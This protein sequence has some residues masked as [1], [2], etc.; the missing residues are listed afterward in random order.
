MISFKGN[1]SG[2]IDQ[3]KKYLIEKYI[4]SL[5]DYRN[6][7]YSVSVFNLTTKEQTID[8]NSHQL[9]RPASVLKIIPCFLS[10]KL[11]ESYYTDFIYKDDTLNV[12]S[13]GDISFLDDSTYPIYPDIHKK[14]LFL[15]NKTK[16]I[17]F[18]VDNNFPKREECNNHFIEEDKG[19]YFGAVPSQYNFRGNR[20]DFHFNIK[21]NKLIFKYVYPNPFMQNVKAIIKYDITY[22]PPGTRDLT[23]IYY[24]NV[25]TD[26]FYILFKGTY[27]LIS[28]E[29]NLDIVIKGCNPINNFQLITNHFFSNTPS[30][31]SPIIV[32]DTSITKLK[33]FYKLNSDSIINSY[34]T[35]YIRVFSN[36][37]NK[38]LNKCLIESNNLIANRLLF[39]FGKASNM[40]HLSCPCDLNV[41]LN[42]LHDTLAQLGLP[43]NEFQLFEGSGLSPENKISTYSLS[44]FLL[45]KQNPYILTRFYDLENGWQ[46]GRSTKN[47]FTK[48]GYME[49]TRSLAGYFVRKDGKMYSFAIIVNDYKGQAGQSKVVVDNILDILSR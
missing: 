12:Y 29:S 34:K 31:N 39:D 5:P 45:K 26:S 37:K 6:S 11:N 48:S 27:P 14:E 41:S 21:D 22:T 8:I 25:N 42:N 36:D 28:K 19:Q 16:V 4:K 33:K 13:N 17:R 24:K 46:N 44:L 18:Y 47:V 23:Y 43:R 7:K 1:C 35:N 15:N 20:V 49:S 2:I 30:V 40:H 9:L 32:L 3:T 38:L 10:Q